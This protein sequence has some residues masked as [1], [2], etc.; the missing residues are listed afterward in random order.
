MRILKNLLA[1]ANNDYFLQNGNTTTQYFTS[2]D[3]IRLSETKQNRLFGNNL[4]N[5]SYFRNE[6]QK[7]LFKKQIS[8]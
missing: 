3:T 1:W 5:K 6:I 2:L 4:E 8:I 7:E